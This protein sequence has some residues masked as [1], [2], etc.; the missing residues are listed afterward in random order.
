MLSKLHLYTSSREL[1]L[2]KR[3]VFSCSLLAYAKIA[4]R[5]GVT[6]CVSG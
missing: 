6:Q 5:A 1:V 4:K 3:Y 2:G